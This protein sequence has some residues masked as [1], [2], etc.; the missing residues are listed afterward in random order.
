M[1]R[2]IKKHISIKEKLIY[3]YIGGVIIPLLLFSLAFFKIQ[4]NTMKNT[5]ADIAYNELVQITGLIDGE[6]EQLMSISNLLYLDS[7]LNNFVK[8]YNQ[9]PD[10]NP[11]T[12]HVNRILNKYNSGISNIN[13]NSVIFTNRGEAIGDATLIHKSDSINI[14]DQ[15]WFKRLMD[16]PSDIL[17]LKDE[18]LDTIFTSAGQDYI[19]LIRELQNRDTWDK[20]GILILGISENELRKLYSGYVNDYSSIFILNEKGSLISA[21]DNLNLN[22]IPKFILNNLYHYTGRDFEEKVND[23]E[24]LMTH[25]TIKTSNWKIFMLN[26]LNYLLSNFDSIRSLYLRVIIIY[27]VITLIL[28]SVFLTKFTKPIQVLYQYMEKVKSNDLDVTVPVVS[29]DEI[30]YL[31]EQFNSMIAEIKQLMENLVKEQEEKRQAELISLQ[32]Q[33]NPH[34]LYN[35][36]ASIRYL[37]YTEKKEDVDNIILSLIRILKYSLSDTKEFISIQKEISILEDYIFIQKYAFSNTVKVDINIDDEILN[38][39]TIKLILQPL[40]ENSFMHGLKPKKENGYLS[41]KGFAKD[42]NVYFEIFD[43]GVGF[44]PNADA[45]KSRKRSIGLKN[46]RE[47]IQL[48]FGE[49]YGLYIESEQNVYTRI[50]V[51]IPKIDG[52]EE[53]HIL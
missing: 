52:E 15:S 46:V 44:D 35:T 8:S 19:Y 40:V 51:K 25:Y 11:D 47:R 29:R 50:T 18:L 22:E 49:G 23:Q 39:K 48:T 24:L 21:I 38:C 5:S 33:I 41:I 37:I 30:G 26:D 12:E 53:I 3:I 32:T 45:D 34:F 28:C 14:S 43:N 27:F 2:N 31:S 42:N 1:K 36:L 9:D 16:R 4:K 17:W 6:L 7:D 13:F 20:T 10:I